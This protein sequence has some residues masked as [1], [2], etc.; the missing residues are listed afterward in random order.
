MIK[1]I[2]IVGGGMAGSEAAWQIVSAG[3]PVI[4]HEMRPS[5]ETFA[6]Q[7]HDLAELVCS[8]SFRSDDDESNAVGLLHWEMRSANSIIMEMG[9]KHALPAGSAL[10][11]DR[12]AFSASVT[13]KITNHPLVTIDRSEIHNLPPENWGHTIIATG[14]LTSK[15][16]ANDILEN[17]DQ[18]S[19]AF[20][21]QLHQLYLQIVS[22]CQKH[23]C[24]HVMIKVKLMKSEQHI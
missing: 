23:G 19:L 4:I 17:T 7:T 11:V 6:H 15:S 5:V 22:I 20:L 8:N 13:K 21:M 18:K 2:H 14:P 24:N 10:A 3:I 12:E 9:D 16:L 1:P